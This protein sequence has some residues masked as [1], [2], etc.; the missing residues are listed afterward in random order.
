MG[1]FGLNVLPFCLLAI[2]ASTVAAA[3][4][5]FASAISIITFLFVFL[6]GAAHFEFS[7]HDL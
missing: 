5:V 2:L 3:I 4:T 6:S 1:G 7:F